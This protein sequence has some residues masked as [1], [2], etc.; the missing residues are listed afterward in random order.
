VLV[1]AVEISDFG[2]GETGTE[3]FGLP[4]HVEDEL[5]PSIPSG[6]RDNFPPMWWSRVG[7][8]LPAFEYQGLKFARAA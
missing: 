2:V 1:A 8:G 6:S 3:F 4:V 5:G 7:A